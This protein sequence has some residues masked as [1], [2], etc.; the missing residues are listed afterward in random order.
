MD[1]EQSLKVMLCTMLAIAVIDTI[2][3]RILNVNHKGFW[4]IYK[5]HN[6]RLGIIEEL[7]FVLFFI[8]IAC[9]FYFHFLADPYVLFFLLAVIIWLIKGIDEWRYNRV[10]K[11]Y[12]FSWLNSG[13]FFFVLLF[14]F[15]G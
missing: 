5:P 11:E 13:V 12:I 3:R 4:R 1:G 15:F 7:V 6:K 9:A 14:K 8:I 2:L 10:E